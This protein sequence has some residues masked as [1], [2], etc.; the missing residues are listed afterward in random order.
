[1]AVKKVDLYVTQLI[2]DLNNGL[3]WFKKDDLGYGSIEVKYGANEKQIA[4]IRKHPLLKDAE[5]NIV[6]FNVIDDTKNTTTKTTEPDI[7][8]MADLRTKT[9]VSEELEAFANL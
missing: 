1:M 2:E 5:T 7:V 6:I 8:P 3:T 9:S 4:A